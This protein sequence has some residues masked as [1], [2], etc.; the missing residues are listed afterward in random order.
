MEIEADVASRGRGD[1][2]GRLG[3]T[4]VFFLLGASVGTWAARIPAVKGELHLG[5]GTL[6]L[7]LLGPALGSALAMPSAGALLATVQPRRVI[8][9]SIVAAGILPV[10]TV[11]TSAWELFIVL[12]FWGAGLGMVDVGMN[13][14]AAAVQTHLGRRIMSRFHGAFSGGTLFGSGLGAL[15]AAEHISAQVNFTVAGAIIFVLGLACA[16]AFV[17]YGGHRVDV[18]AAPTRQR[19]WPTWSMRLAALSLIVFAAFLSEGAVEDWSA[20]YLHTSL[21]ASLGIAAIG[22]TVFSSVM[23]GGRLAGDNLANFAGPVKLVRVSAC[24]GALALGAALV[25]GNI[26]VGIVGFGLLAAGLASVVPL[27]FSSAAGLGQR[28]PNLAFVTTCGYVGML[29][30]PPMIGG[31]A[32]VFGLPGAFGVVVALMVL[33]VVLSGAFQADSAVRAMLPPPPADVVIR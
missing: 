2:L 13:T 32:D 4:A 26:W 19:R 18:G 23:T 9:S 29:T 12:V 1:T 7:C 30:G 6:G 10:T 11:V 31:L 33:I 3:L 8:Q 14:Q 27:A 20:V 15:A 25:V 16:Q 17:P 28:G 21:G 24:I 5:A 22:Y